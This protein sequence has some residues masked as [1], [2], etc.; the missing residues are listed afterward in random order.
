MKITLINIIVSVI[1]LAVV[2]GLFYYNRRPLDTIDD[3]TT[4]ALLRNAEAN[5]YNQWKVFC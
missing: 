2:A 3:M 1:T 5:A 4:Y